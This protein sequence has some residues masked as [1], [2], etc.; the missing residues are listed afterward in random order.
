MANGLYKIESIGRRT[1]LTPEGNFVEVYTVNF[2]TKSGVTSYVEI[3]TVQFSTDEVAK[4]VTAEAA[5][6][7]SVLEL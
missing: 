1:I 3:P 5:E 4:R 7:E 2:T 6:I